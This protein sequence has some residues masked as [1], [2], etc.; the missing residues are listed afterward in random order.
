MELKFFIIFI[1]LTVGIEFILIVPL[2]NFVKKIRSR[3]YSDIDV[4]VIAN[5]VSEGCSYHDD[6]RNFL[7]NWA[8]YEWSYNGKKHDLRVDD[9][10][11]AIPILKNRRYMYHG[12]SYPKTLKVTVN[13]KTGN[14]KEPEADRKVHK[15]NVWFSLLAFVIAY[16][17]TIKLTGIN[18]LIN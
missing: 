11:C 9:M 6:D 10:D 16:Y 7:V 15:I 2:L 8:I 4:E 1:L 18:P 3:D 13:K 12:G 17:L 5:K 14:C